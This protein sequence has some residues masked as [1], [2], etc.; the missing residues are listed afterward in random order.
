MAFP[1]SDL[2][3]SVYAYLGA[4]PTAAP[5]TWPAPT[6]LT[7]RLLDPPVSTTAGR[8]R[9]Q[10]TLSSISTT[11]VLKNDDGA[12]TALL[13]SSPYYGTWDLGVPMR[14]AISGVGASP[15]Y[16]WIT[17]FVVS[18]KPTVV[19][20]PSG[21]STSVVVVMLGGKVRQLSQG[22][23][24]KSSAMRG[25]LASSPRAY[26]PLNDGKLATHGTALTTTTKQARLTAL[27]DGVPAPGWG[28]GSL[29]PWLEDAV[30]V[31]GDAHLPTYQARSPRAWRSTSPWRTSRPP[32]PT[33]R[34]GC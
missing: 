11:F 3:L 6:D 13:P 32:R 22:S 2:Q 33:H 24:A 7:S 19:Q 28:S 23:V 14:L 25:I 20:S 17:G 10:A 8:G 26:W 5:G 29:A 9:G 34:T 27:A 31:P 4:D 12:L 1:D 16:D 30:A 15:P 18:I 21:T